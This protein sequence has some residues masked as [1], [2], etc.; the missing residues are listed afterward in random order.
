MHWKHVA[1]ITILAAPVIF[2]QDLNEQP[3][4]PIHDPREKHFANVRQLTFGGI[5]AE[6][7]FSFDEKKI[8]FQSTR[9]PFKCDQIFTMNVDGSNVKLVSTGKG[10]TTCSY[11]LLGDSEIIYSSTHL[12]DTACPPP[13][14]FKQGYVWKFYDEY[15]IFKAK[16]DGS[17]LR[18]LTH[19]PGYDAE[20]TVSPVEAKI[21]FTS[22]RNGDLGI[23]TMDFDGGHVIRL[24]D[25]LGYE[26][27][28]Y[29]SWDGKKVVYRAFYPKDS[30][31]IRE[32][33]NLLAKRLLKPVVIEI[34]VADSDGKNIRQVTKHGAASFAPFFYP[35]NEHIVYASNVS[36]PQRRSFQLR[37]IR[38]DGS[39]DEQITYA[40][41]F[42][43]FPMFTHDG[44]K[45][46]F[47]SNR[48]AKAP[49]EMN[50]FIADWIP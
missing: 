22:F 10:R 32:Y 39:E 35:D 43:S 26:G 17:N 47:C 12:T 23:Y 20:A 1:V 13:P 28:P 4:S 24:I 16:T 34:Y 21:I 15:E 8:I 41:T 3:I 19:N 9:P 29:Y 11:Y 50:V 40:G 45:I 6:A 5:N 7:Y 49:H 38:E 33:E 46:I 42:N 36:D 48:N 44:K 18:Q 2:A 25:S 31:A 14:D 30:A 37:M 27:G